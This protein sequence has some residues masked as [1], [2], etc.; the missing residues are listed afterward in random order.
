MDC[1]IIISMN[2]KD[3]IPL[4]D[5]AIAHT[6]H[7]IPVCNFGFTYCTE[8]QNSGIVVKRLSEISSSCN[9]PSSENR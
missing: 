2:I 4:M 7:V 1:E 9:D 5:H 8:F 3:H 6:W